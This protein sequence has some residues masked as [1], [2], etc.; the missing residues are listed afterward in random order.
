MHGSLADVGAA[1]MNSKPVLTHAQCAS[2]HAYAPGLFR[3]VGKGERKTAKLDVLYTCN[4]NLMMHY[5][6]PEPLGADDLR[7]FLGLIA[8]A[9]LGDEDGKVMV[10]PEP[11]SELGREL[12]SLMGLKQ[13][14][15]AQL[16]VVKGSFRRLS[17]AIGLAES[18][19]TFDLL[20]QSIER[21][22]ETTVIRITPTVSADGKQGVKRQ[23]FRLLSRADSDSSAGTLLVALNPALTEAIT[24]NAHYL[25]MALDEMRQLKS[26]AALLAWFRLQFIN[27]GSSAKVGVDTLCGYVWPG[28]ASDATMRKRRSR[29]YEVLEELKTIGY[30]IERTGGVVN[31]TRPKLLSASVH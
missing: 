14:D 11:Q 19:R 4:E 8:L 21:L 26:D 12:R 28:E 6:G 3:S 22:F 25:R 24:G 27:R 15:R 30:G 18:G 7:V 29:M 20:R 17:S 10:G 31:I 13:D 16:S 23:P 5:R 1:S 2:S 9:G